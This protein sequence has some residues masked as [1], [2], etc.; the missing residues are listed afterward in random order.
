M[1]FFALKLTV[2][3]TLSPSGSRTTFS[4]SQVKPV[5]W[6]RFLSKIQL[7]WPV[8]EV[9]VTRNTRLRFVP[10]TTLPKSQTCH[11]TTNSAGSPRLGLPAERAG[12]S[13]AAAA[14]AGR[15]AISMVAMA[16]SSPFSARRGTAG[17]AVEAASTAERGEAWACAARRPVR[18]SMKTRRLASISISICE[19][20]GSPRFEWDVCSPPRDEDWRDMG[21]APIGVPWR[22]GEP[23]GPSSGPPPLRFDCDVFGLSRLVVDMAAAPGEIGRPVSTPAS[24]AEVAEG[25]SGMRSSAGGSWER[26]GAIR[27]SL[28]TSRVCCHV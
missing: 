25:G 19:S 3:C 8:D 17:P 20:L 23:P 9:L 14:P 12:E 1:A 10:L 5:P 2:N 13:A 18:W 24:C 26:S 16:P 28:A 22:L 6:R 21:G 7:S 15:V 11:A 4:G 27:C